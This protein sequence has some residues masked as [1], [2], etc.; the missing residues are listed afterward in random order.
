MSGLVMK[1][2]S[3]PQVI[4]ILRRKIKDGNSY[5]D[6][7]EAWLP[8]VTGQ[9]QIP[10]YVVNASKVDDDS[11][12]ISI[13]LVCA[14]LEEV[15][16]ESS[17]VRKSD[18]DR[19]DKVAEVADSHGNA[20]LF[21]VKNI[22]ELSDKN[23]EDIFIRPMMKYDIDDVVTKFEEIGWKDKNKKLFEKYIDELENGERLVWIAFYKEQFAGFVTLRW[24]SEY[25]HF[26]KA[27]IPEIMD[28]NTLPEFRGQGVGASLLETAESAASKSANFVGLG[29]GISPEYSNAQKLY[30][31]KGYI[32]D[33]YGPTY[34]YKKIDK[35]Q[36]ITLDDDLLIW[37]KKRL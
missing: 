21:V 6:F 35:G 15:Y 17:R 14:S 12:T 19:R 3:K 18:E 7:R 22:D 2:K 8:E 36:K 32:L 11:E 24:E 4:S 13:G 9:Y 28:L 33:G 37:F 30:T 1:L 10:T 34:K 25:E 29:C 16:A 5:D 20:E 26:K 27:D 23:Y 31:C